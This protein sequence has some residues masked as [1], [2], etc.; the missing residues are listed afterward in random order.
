MS[1]WEKILEIE[2]DLNKKF[3]TE[4][5]LVRLGDKV[6]LRLPSIPTGLPTLDYEVIGTGGV[7]RGRLVEIFGPESSGKTSL[8]LHIIGCEQ[9]LGGIAAFI[10][11]EHALD[12]SWASLLGVNVD[13]LLVSQPD[14]GEQALQTVEALIESGAVSLIVVDSVAALVP[15]AELEGEIGDAHIGLQARLMSQACRKLTAKC[16]AYDVT[17][18]FINQIREKIGVMFGNPETTSGGR[19]LKFYSSVR[20]D[21]RR[22]EAIKE[23]SELVGHEI[24]LKAVKNKVGKPF[25]ETVV[26]LLYTKGFDT[27]SDLIDFAVNT[28]V[29]EKSGV[30]YKFEGESLRKEG[31]TAI[32]D[33][34]KV[35]L[36]T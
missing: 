12:P 19:A 30:W 6:G 7:P 25:S 22:K 15:L 32:L 14:S 1:K 18:I 26:N 23:E 24:K 21:V 16:K 10:D 2:K 4:H 11:A 35:K 29:I 3:S 8:S 36:P 28:G 20:I 5:S 27:D 34:V 33:R 17:L 13:D 31:L 9:R